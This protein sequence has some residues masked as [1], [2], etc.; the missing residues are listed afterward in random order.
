MCEADPER[1]RTESSTIHSTRSKHIAGVD[2]ILYV[3]V[4]PG[5]DTKTAMPVELQ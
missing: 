4:D 3:V 1:G 5:L 2:L